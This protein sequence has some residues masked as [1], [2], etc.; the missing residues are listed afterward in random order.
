MPETSAK[1]IAVTYSDSPLGTK[2][3]TETVTEIP[4]EVNSV[5]RTE[6]YAAYNSGFLPEYLV[7]THSANYGG[8]GIIDILTA[9][10][11]VRCDIYRT[12]N[13]GA[14]TVELYCVKKNPAVPTVFTLWTGGRIVKLYGAYLSGNDSVSRETNGKVSDGTVTLILPQSLKAFCGNVGVGYVRPKAYA[15]MS[16]EEKAESFYIDSSCFFAVGDIDAEGK[17]QA[18]NAAYD[19]VYLVKGVAVKNNGKPDT[20]YVEVTG[21]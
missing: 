9:S 15:A 2:A 14:G 20:E 8:Q 13:R 10:G 16:N 6:F 17:Y 5:G 1:L 18:I 21:K 11:E 4:C 12:Y 19:D 3:A 7:T